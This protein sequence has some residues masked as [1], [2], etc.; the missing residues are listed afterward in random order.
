MKPTRFFTPENLQI[1]KRIISRYP[2][3]QER[4]SLVPLLDLAQRQNGTWIPPSAMQEIANSTGL[5]FEQVHSFILGYPTSFEWRPCAPQLRICNS[6]MCCHKAKQQD[7]D[8]FEAARSVAQPY[9]VEVK[10]TG[11]LGACYGAPAF[12][13]NDKIHTDATKEF[14]KQVISKEL[15]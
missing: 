7:Y 3:G 15:S 14:I 1:V 9:G 13:F 12:W 10:T 4:A 6:W 11:C 2:S 8:I 5:S